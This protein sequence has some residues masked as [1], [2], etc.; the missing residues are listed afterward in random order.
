MKK[1][2]VVMRLALTLIVFVMSVMFNVSRAQADA[3]LSIAPTDGD[4][5]PKIVLVSTID[6]KRKVT[7][8]F[9]IS[10]SVPDS[11]VE[12]TK[13]VTSQ[14]YTLT[15]ADGAF[16]SQGDVTV[17]T[18]FTVSPIAEGDHTATISKTATGDPV[19]WSKNGDGNFTVTASVYCDNKSGGDKDKTIKL[20]GS[21]S[22]I[23]AEGAGKTV[24][25]NPNGEVKFT[26]V[27]VTMENPTGDPVLNTAREDVNE[28]T[29]DSSS[30][31]YCNIVCRAKLEPDTAAT[32]EWAE[33]NI[34]WT[35]TAT[36]GYEMKPIS[37]RAS[38]PLEYNNNGKDV[39]LQLVV[40]PDDNGSFGL[41]T[42][43][44]TGGQAGKIT[45]NIQIFFNR[46]ATNHPGD[47]QTPTGS[48]STRSP[49][50]F[51]YWGKAI[52]FS[53][54]VFYNSNTPADA[55]AGA[56]P[57]ML[58][59]AN[60]LAYSKTEIWLND[61]AVDSY[62]RR[63]GSNGVASGI[64]MVANVLAHES[65]HIAQI[66]AADALL[67]QNNGVWASGWS[68]NANPNNHYTPGP[69]VARLSPLNS[70]WPTA[71]PVPANPS[72]APN[73]LEAD[74]RLHETVA[75]DTHMASDFANNG[76]QHRTN[77]R[78]DD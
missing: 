74:A 36:G 57:A 72:G 35:T 23:D 61:P 58:K 3:T 64:D 14:S 54:N 28:F 15:A 16:E 43:S 55:G 70:D 25:S 9:T 73:E 62:K 69:L 51:Y 21:A 1:N 44:M 45:R 66:A 67:T 46:D 12:F 59:W 20:T 37:N 48:G 40:L 53:T 5:A 4:A 76:K 78:W 60:P 2:A 22:Y 32:T 68:W 41:K 65:Q 29:Y 17:D 47:D 34:S 75:Q 30:N 13:K 50:W 26:A 10:L 7:A 33:N 11:D 24:T 49:N 52:G 63:D 42:V 19:D 39:T 27:K 38:G 18:G 71:W 31:G 8:T 56:A 6:T 77:G